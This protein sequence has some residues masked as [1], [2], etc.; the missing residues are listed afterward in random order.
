MG[1]CQQYIMLTTRCQDPLTYYS[2][3]F[4]FNYF[5][6]LKKYIQ[7][8]HS[9]I[10]LPGRKKS[11]IDL[12]G[13][14]RFY[15][16]TESAPLGRVSWKAVC[17]LMG[18]QTL[19]ALLLQRWPL[20]LRHILNTFRPDPYRKKKNSKKVGSLQEK[21]QKWSKQWVQMH[22]IYIQSLTTFCY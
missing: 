17:P 14:T 21:F 13:Y 1:F 6:I 15:T 7:I 2:D 8:G 5:F 4:I 22:L 16:F 19:S 12:Y 18:A 9:A 20:S 10:Y 3:S 11:K